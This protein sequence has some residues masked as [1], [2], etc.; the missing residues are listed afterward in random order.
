MA[1]TPAQVA[2]KWQRNIKNATT[3]IRD[4]VTATTES[5][6]EKAADAAD[7]WINRLQEAHSSGKFAARLR[8]VPLETWKK[9]TIEVGIPRIAAGADKAVSDLERFYGELFSFQEIIGREL[10]AMSDVTLEDSIVRM[11]HNMR[12]MSEFSRS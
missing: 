9:N 11:T 4:G 3:E 8:A 6:M 2:A 1:R 10:D 12:R 7:K 5:P